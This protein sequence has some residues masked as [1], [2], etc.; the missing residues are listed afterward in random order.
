MYKEDE[1]VCVGVATQPGKKDTSKTFI[2][3]QLSIRAKTMTFTNFDATPADLA[4]AQAMQGK[5]TKGTVVFDLRPVGNF[6]EA[7]IEFVSFT[8]S[9]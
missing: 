4:A 7:G 6:A 2:K 3:Y 8:P 1:A 5:I 9:E